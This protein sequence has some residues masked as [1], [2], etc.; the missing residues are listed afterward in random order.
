MTYQYSLYC[1]F[2]DERTTS[3]KTKLALHQMQQHWTGEGGKYIINN[4]LT[5][6]EELRPTNKQ[7]KLWSYFSVS[8][9]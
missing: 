5:E 9:T 8:Q 2:Q 4:K 7:R 1:L 6:Q 3:H